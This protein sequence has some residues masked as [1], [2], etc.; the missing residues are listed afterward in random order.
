M[1]ASWPWHRQTEVEEEP[2]R[3]APVPPIGERMSRRPACAAGPMRA[4]VGQASV[5]GPLAMQAKR[6]ACGETEDWAAQGDEP[7][8][9]RQATVASWRTPRGGT[10]GPERAWRA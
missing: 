5:A 8:E 4:G 10:F 9:G 3:W 6:C 1:W 7:E 2:D